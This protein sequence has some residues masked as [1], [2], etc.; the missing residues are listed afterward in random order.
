MV[1]PEWIDSGLVFT[2]DYGQP[3]YGSTVTKQLQR[4]LR[5]AGLLGRDSMISGT[6]RPASCWRRASRR[7]W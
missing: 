4:L 6:A 1:G 2:N 7:E 3:L 5:E